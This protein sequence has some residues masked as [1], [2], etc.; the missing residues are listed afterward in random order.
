MTRHRGAISPPAVD[1]IAFADASKARSD[2]TRVTPVA[3][4][5]S[6]P[7]AIGFEISW[8][9]D[10]PRPTIVGDGCK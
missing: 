8:K 6:T 2:L 7:V 4:A 9:V 10:E 1:L 5:I 3:L